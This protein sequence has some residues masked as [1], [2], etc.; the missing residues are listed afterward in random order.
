MTTG[1]YHYTEAARLIAQAHRYTYGDGADP[2]VGGA[3]AMEAVANAVNGLTAATVM[4]ARINAVAAII[5]DTDLEAWGEVIPPA[6]R[7][8][9]WSREVRRPE[10]AERHT[11][12]CFYAE[13]EH[14]LLPIGTRV[15]VSERR[16]EDE[17][18]PQ[19]PYAAK[20]VG[21]D[22][23][24]SKYRLHP[25]SSRNAGEYVEVDR[26][27]FADNRVQVHPA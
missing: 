2:V 1:P 7:T 23:H 26:W 25:A 19:Q 15:L 9:C 22:M 3:L 16:Y 12:D 14:K 27:A 10:C 4:A 11:E 18:Y 13:P 8:E 20:I 17:D 21:Y 6:P 24:R 5:R